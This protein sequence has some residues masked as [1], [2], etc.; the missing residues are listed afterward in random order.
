LLKEIAP[1]TTLDEL[2]QLTAAPFRAVP[3]LGSMI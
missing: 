2:K 1:D 3:N